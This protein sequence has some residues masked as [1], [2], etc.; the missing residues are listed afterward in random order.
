MAAYVRAAKSI[1]RLAE[2]RT[3]RELVESVW[4]I[5]QIQTAA[6][7]HPPA[8]SPSHWISVRLNI[9]IALRVATM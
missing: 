7:G 3:V 8:L 4:G 2:F 1:V 6:D 9:H 5:T